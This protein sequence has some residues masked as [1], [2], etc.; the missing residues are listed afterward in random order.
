MAMPMPSTPVLAPT[1][2]RSKRLP[3]AVPRVLR[4]QARGI[5][6]PSHGGGD[7]REGPPTIDGPSRILVAVAGSDGTHGVTDVKPPN[8]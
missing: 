5:G 2:R 8:H 6:T 7:M 4:Q 1:N 3:H